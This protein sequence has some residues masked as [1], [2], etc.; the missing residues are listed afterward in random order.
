M[1][2][3]T[4]LI[5]KEVATTGIAQYHHYGS[6]G[7]LE[8]VLFELMCYAEVRGDVFNG[9]NSP[10]GEY[11]QFNDYVYYV[12]TKDY[13]LVISLTTLGKKKS[14]I[15]FSVRKVPLE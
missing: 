5:L 12:I 9:I 8:D 13:S 15:S 4:K 11:K 1:N 2:T 7:Y 14:I 6:F 10:Y 3:N